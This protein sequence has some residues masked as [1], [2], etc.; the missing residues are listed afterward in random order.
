V[1]YKPPR[2]IA[3]LSGDFARVAGKHDDLLSLDATRDYFGEVYWR[4]GAELDAKCV[5]AVFKVKV[6]GNGTDFAYRTVAEN[7]CLIESGLLPAIVVPEAAK[8][9]A[10][11]ISGAGRPHRRS[12]RKLQPY[13][14]QVPPRNLLLANGHVRFVD[15]KRFGNHAVL[16]T[17]GLYQGNIGLRRRSNIAARRFDHLREV[18]R[19]CPTVFAC[20]SRATTPVSRGRR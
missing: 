3:Q 19:Q 11:G 18:R 16:K 15:E 6:N 17:D 14:V 20:S 8:K 2:Q 7:F 4:K 12:T 1:E 10:G 13:R 5:L 9:R